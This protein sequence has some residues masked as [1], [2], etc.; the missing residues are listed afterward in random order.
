MTGNKLAVFG[1]IAAISGGFAIGC[2]SLSG[3]RAQQ[4]TLIDGV[5]DS[6]AGA[7]IDE[8]NRLFGAL[9]G[10]AL[11]A[12]GGYLI[13]ADTDWFEDPNRQMRAHD[14]VRSAENSPATVDEVRRSF[15][16]DLNLDGFVTTDELIAMDRAGLSDD[17]ILTRLRATA[18][19]FELS[20]SQ[21]RAMARAG[22]SHRV[23]RDLPDINHFER[24]L[25]LGNRY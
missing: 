22:V 17:V 16:A 5:A 11:G 23:I 13:G 12:R 9:I 21:Q 1:T 4:G 15:T 25:V 24:E 10:G 2:E 3:T 8:E 7:T 6:E 14:A 20:G 18:Q 19:V